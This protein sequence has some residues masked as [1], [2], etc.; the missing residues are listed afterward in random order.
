MDFPIHRAEAVKRIR[1][2]AEMAVADGIAH[3]EKFAVALPNNFDVEVEI[4][5]AQPRSARELLSRR[6][7]GSAPRT[8]QLLLRR[9]LRRAAVLHVSACNSFRHAFGMPPPSKREAYV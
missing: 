1:E 5:E 7:G 9:V 8:V 2:K 3:P 6:E 4:C